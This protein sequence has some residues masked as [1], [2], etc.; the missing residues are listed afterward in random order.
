MPAPKQRS[1]NPFDFCFTWTDNWYIWDAKEARTQ[2]RQAR[3][4]KARELRSHG[5]TVDKWCLPNQLVRRGGIGTGHPDIEQ[6]V[7]VYMLDIQ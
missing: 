1:F 3:D 2:A 6:Y 4:A 5:L 7:T